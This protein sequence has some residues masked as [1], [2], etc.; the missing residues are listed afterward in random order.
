MTEYCRVCWKN[1]K[2]PVFTNGMCEFHFKTLFYIQIAVGASICI[3]MIFW[4]YI[5]TVGK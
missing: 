3:A 1:H 5:M 4:S 2:N